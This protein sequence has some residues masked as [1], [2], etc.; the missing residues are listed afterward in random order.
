[1]AVAQDFLL[2]GLGGDL[3]I[4]NG[5]FVIGS[6]D[7][8]AQYDIINDPQGW[9]KQYLGLGVGLVT[10]QNGNVNITALSTNI[11]KQLKSDGFT[12]RSPKITFN[13]SGILNVIPNAIRN[14]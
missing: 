8:Q 4:K 14:S 12:T 7:V 10:Q 11:V 2:N 6:S 9:W 5:D 1:M 3:L 13:N